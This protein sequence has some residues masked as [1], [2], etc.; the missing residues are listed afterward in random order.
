MNYD[1][2]RI[3][4]QID[5]GLDL[6]E[7]ILMLP[8]NLTQQELESRIK[9][10]KT[11][12]CDSFTNEVKIL[13]H[14][15]LQTYYKALSLKINQPIYKISGTERRKLK[16]ELTRLK[17]YVKNFWHYHQLDK[18]MASFYGGKEGY[19]MSDEDAQNKLDVLNNK[20]KVLEDSLKELYE[21]NV[22]EEAKDCPR[23]NG[24]GFYSYG[25][26]F[27]GTAKTQRCYCQEFK[28]D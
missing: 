22:S 12:L 7:E 8:E 9:L 16:S 23:C 26:S 21:P 10:L 24:T 20:V 6:R 13:I 18:D 19:P 2:N 14:Q 28:N 11:M 17:S 27:G 5:S 1:K 15:E 3:S 4:D 25:G